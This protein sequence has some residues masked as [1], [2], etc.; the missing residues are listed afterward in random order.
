VIE[1]INNSTG[2]I[3]TTISTA[4]IEALRSMKMKKLSVAAPYTDAIMGKLKNFLE[5]NDFEVVKTKSL[6]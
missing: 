1:A 6:I 3:A 4:V 2:I 5:K